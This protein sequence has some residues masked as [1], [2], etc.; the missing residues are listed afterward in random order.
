GGNRN[1]VLPGRRAARR[2][3]PPQARLR[4]RGAGAGRGGRR[5][6]RARAR[7]PAPP[8]RYRRP[9]RADPRAR[10]RAA[11]RRDRRRA[12]RGR[13]RGDER[14]GP[15]GPVPQSRREPAGPARGRSRHRRRG[16]DDRGSRR[17]RAGGGALRD[18]AR[19]ARRRRAGADLSGGVRRPPDGTRPDRGARTLVRGPGHRLSPLRRRAAHRFLGGVRSRSGAQAGRHLRLELD[20][21]HPARRRHGRR[22]EARTDADPRRHGPGGGRA[23]F[24]EIRADLR[25]GGRRERG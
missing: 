24:P 10:P 20:P 5:G 8:R 12:R 19:R 18:G 4:A 22:D 23:P 16:G 13:V 7:A 25:G 14:L 11:R 15:R 6:R 3:R 1:L 21:A 9:V 2:G 17:R